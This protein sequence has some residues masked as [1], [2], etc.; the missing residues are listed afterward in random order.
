MEGMADHASL[1]G[2]MGG[3]KRG[4]TV[5]ITSESELEPVAVSGEE[6][7]FHAEYYPWVHGL[8]V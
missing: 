2:P 7:E 1:I 6:F 3:G 8:G 5:L 4:A